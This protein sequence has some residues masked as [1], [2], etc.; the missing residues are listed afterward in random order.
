M[1]GTAD[2]DLAQ[3][4]KEITKGEKTAEVMETQLAILE[5]KIDELLAS[6]DLPRER[7][8][9]P[10]EEGGGLHEEG[11]LPEEEG[12]DEAGEESMTEKNNSGTE[13]NRPEKG[14]EG[15]EAEKGR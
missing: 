6:V 1:P 2:L 3:A 11:G 13:G 8:P 4:L 7:D 9:I 10:P 14:E 15:G 12:S 5:R